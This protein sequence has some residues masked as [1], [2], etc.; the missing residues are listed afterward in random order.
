MQLTLTP[1][2]WGTSKQFWINMGPTRLFKLAALPDESLPPP[3]QLFIDVHE[4]LPAETT[5]MQN[6]KRLPQ[7]RTPWSM[8]PQTWVT[9]DFSS[10]FTVYPHHM[11][12]QII[13]LTLMCAVLAHSARKPST[14][15][16]FLRSG[17]L[18]CICNQCYCCS[19][20]GIKKQTRI[21]HSLPYLLWYRGQEL[22]MLTFPHCNRSIVILKMLYFLSVSYKKSSFFFF[23]LLCVLQYQHHLKPHSGFVCMLWCRLYHLHHCHQTRE[24]ADLQHFTQQHVMTLKVTALV[25]PILCGRTCTASRGH[26]CYPLS[27]YKF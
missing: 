7:E 4:S 3:E 19:L 5:L 26:A 18:H 10:F 23:K 1:M 16:V 25:M 9:R 17:S 13:R 20:H 11:K 15:W 14:N 27:V 22:Y 8:S 21:W 6:L 12:Y 24:T 2:I